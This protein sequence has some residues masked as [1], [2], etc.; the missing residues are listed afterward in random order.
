MAEQDNN[1]NSWPPHFQPFVNQ[2]AACVHQANE[3]TTEMLGGFDGA[4]DPHAW[5][6]QW[7]DALSSNADAYLRSA[8]F[9]QVMKAHIE[10]MILAKKAG[11]SPPDTPG[12]GDAAAEDRLGGLEARLEHLEAAVNV[13]L[14]QLE[15]RVGAMDQQP[16]P[17]GP[18]D[19]WDRFLEALRIPRTDTGPLQGVT[20]H[21]VVYHEGPLRLLRYRPLNIR[22]AEPILICFAL[23]NRPYVLDL[24]ADRSVIQRLLEQ[25]FVV[26]LIDW[27]V[28]TSA[29]QGLRLHDYVG[30]YLCNVTEV[31]CGEAATPQLNLLGYCMGGTMSTIYTALQP[32]RVRNLILMATPIDFGGEE[33]LLNVW[34]RKDHFDVDQLIDT[35]G[36]CPG[37]FLQYC[38]Q[39]MKPVQNFTEKYLTLCE[40]LGDDAF[41]DN[42]FAMERWASD[43]IPVAGETFREY[44]KALYQQNQLV[45]GELSLDGARVRLREITCP[46]LLLVADQD[47]L[48]PP[49]SSTAL[50]RHVGS[51]EVKSLSIA[52][53][54]IGL[55]VSS[56]AHRQL[57][58]QATN[59]IADHSTA[60]V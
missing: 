34:A 26:Y 10:A 16:A 29:D 22:Y 28:P 18:A 40:K 45:K 1:P 11:F 38:F 54:H 8:P 46:V 36:N 57:W 27:G 41:L 52:A 50:R 32:R 49:S 20:P 33:G 12:S 55:A 53:G 58:P 9:L 2:W 37:E 21:E 7:F 19:G 17:S 47:H 31:V 30:R 60:K 56:K 44:V 48:V 59:W 6:R 15:Q 35:Y 42:F 3:A 14:E 43:S 4:S 24:Q 13:R 51:A 25:G 23:V 5:R 39:L